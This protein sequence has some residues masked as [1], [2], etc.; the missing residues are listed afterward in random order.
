MK[1]MELFESRNLSYMFTIQYYTNWDEN[2]TEMYLL[3]G[4]LE[5]VGH[6]FSM[7]MLLQV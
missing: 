3:E 7:R 2:I 6:V 5:Y 1:C 4:G